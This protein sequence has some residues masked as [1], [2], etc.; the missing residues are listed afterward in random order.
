MWDHIFSQKKHNFECFR[1]NHPKKAVDLGIIRGFLGRNTP[2]LRMRVYNECMF[3]AQFKKLAILHF[4]PVSSKKIRI[5]D[6]FPKTAGQTGDLW[7]VAHLYVLSPLANLILKIR[8]LIIS[9]ELEP[10]CKLTCKKRPKHNRQNY[11][12][13]FVFGFVG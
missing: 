13:K 11:P 4:H 8:W 7:I 12:R 2:D 10:H 1:E 5:I 3:I 6:T 9:V